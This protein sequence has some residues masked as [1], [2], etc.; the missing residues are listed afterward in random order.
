MG[1]IRRFLWRILSAEDAT[2]FTRRD[3]AEEPA[4]PECRPT[5]ETGDLFSIETG[6]FR[7]TVHDVQ[8]PHRNRTL[9]Q[10]LSPQPSPTTP[11]GAASEA[12]VNLSQGRGRHFWYSWLTAAATVGV[13]TY[14]TARLAGAIV[15]GVV[16]ITCTAA[17]AMLPARAH[18][19]RLARRHG[20]PLP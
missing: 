8:C 5:R 11:L 16:V 13:L 12:P 18:R 10:A 6:G 3:F 20:R 19:A 2:D 17:I 14:T 9:P 1:P 15:A 7:V 4:C